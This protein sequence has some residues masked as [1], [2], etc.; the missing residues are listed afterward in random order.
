MLIQLNGNKVIESLKKLPFD[1]VTGSFTYD[2]NNNPVKTAKMIKI[3]DG[4]YKFDS[5]AGVE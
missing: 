2:E 1:G 5:D 3:V 4:N